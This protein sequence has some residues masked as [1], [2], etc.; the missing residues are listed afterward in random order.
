MLRN[1]RSDQFNHHGVPSAVQDERINA[2]V[3]WAALRSWEGN[4]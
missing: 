3:D 2:I 4:P 1:D